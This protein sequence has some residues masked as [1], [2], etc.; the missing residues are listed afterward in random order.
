MSQPASPAVDELA[1]ETPDEAYRR[2]VVAKIE[3][4]LADSEAGRT[5]PHA[6]VVAR[7]RARFAERRE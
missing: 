7:M 4:G 1:L 3:A 2:H 5:I 6:E